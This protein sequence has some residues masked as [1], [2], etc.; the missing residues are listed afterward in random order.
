MNVFWRL[1]GLSSSTCWS[2]SESAIVLADPALAPTVRRTQTWLERCVTVSRGG[3]L[4]APKPCEVQLRF[5]L[6]HRPVSEHHWFTMAGI[7]N[8]QTNGVD[9][10]HDVCAAQQLARW[11]PWLEQLQ[12]YY[13][14]SLCSCHLKQPHQ[15]KLVILS[16]RAGGTFESM[17]L[18]SSCVV[19]SIFH[20]QTWAYAVKTIN[21][22]LVLRGFNM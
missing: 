6:L 13:A 19:I 18:W 2:S 1:A 22:S 4:A 15:V 3:N 17:V 20:L 5:W 14:S 8:T 11:I 10:A 21:C 12:L 9:T 16:R 7:S